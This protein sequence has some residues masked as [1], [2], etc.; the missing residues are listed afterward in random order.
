MV[1]VASDATVGASN[2]G[3]G[4]LRL[5][6]LLAMAMF[7]LVVDTSLM[8]VS[9]SA[10]VHDLGTTGELG[11]VRDRARGARLGGVHPDQQQGRGPDR[12]QAGVRAGPAGLRHRRAGDD[13]GPGHH[14]DRDL[15]GDHRRPGRLP[16]AAGHAVA[17]PRQL[18]G[19]RPEEDVCARRRVGCDRRGDRAAARGV[20]DDLPVLAGRVPARGDRDRDHPVADQA[21]QGRA[22]HGRPALRRSR[23]DPFGP[24]HGRGCARHPGLAGG[25]RLCRPADRARRTCA[26]GVRPLARATAPR[27]QGH[28]ARPGPVPAP[29]LPARNHQ[30][31]R[32]RTSRSAAR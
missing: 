27:G 26:G 6:L 14:G 20:P 32:C 28:G 2:E 10:V 11:P 29:A 1:P 15:L 24:R 5:S 25:R 7:V 23:S 31:R 30:G 21:R 18:R 4:N 17:D 22:V 3:Q 16:V 8:N 9:I 12:P 13:A 19:G